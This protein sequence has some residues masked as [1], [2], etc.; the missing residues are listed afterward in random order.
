M[1]GAEVPG[2]GRVG[3]DGE[4]AGDLRQLTEKA[5]DLANAG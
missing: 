2:K 1:G 4:E 3:L 5:G